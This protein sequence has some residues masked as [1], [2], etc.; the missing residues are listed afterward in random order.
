MATKK[1]WHDSHKES[2]TFGQRLADSVATGMGSWRFI[3]IQTVIV[4]IW[5]ILNVVAFVA[6]WDVY[7]FILLNL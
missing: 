1:T 3:I 4:A 2:M 5:M 7:P 6:H